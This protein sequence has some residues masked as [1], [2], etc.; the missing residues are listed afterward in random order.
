MKKSQIG[1][2]QFERIAQ[3]LNRLL[4]PGL[5]GAACH[6]RAPLF[7]AEV[8]GETPAQ[9]RARQAVAASVCAGCPAR[10]RCRAITDELPRRLR[11]GVWSGRPY[12]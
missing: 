8:N 4:G 5:P 10:A 9:R 12:C 2:W 3:E 7:D 11:G 6:G 1:G